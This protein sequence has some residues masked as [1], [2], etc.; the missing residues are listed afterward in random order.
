MT[1]NQRSHTGQGG[2]I[3]FFKMSI[4]LDIFLCVWSC[5]F[6][7]GYFGTDINI[8]IEVYFSLAGMVQWVSVDL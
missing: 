6:L 7:C 3:D 8:V 2:F 5:I 4:R 1:L